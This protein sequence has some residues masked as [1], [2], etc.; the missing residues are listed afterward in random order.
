[1]PDTI[2]LGLVQFAMTPDTDANMAKAI[3]GIRDAARQGATVVCLPEL[4]RSPYFCQTEDADHFA[5]AEAIPGPSTD[6][7]AEVTRE[8][9]VVVVGSLFERR[10]KGLYHNTAAILDG[11]AGYVGK[12]RKM[13]IPDDPLFYEKY[14]FAPGDLGFKTWETSRGDLG[15]LI[16]W[17]QWY[18][19]AARLTAL[20]GADVLFYPTAIGWHPS[21]KAEYG[22]AQR[23]AWITAQRAHAISNGVYVAAVNR[24]GFEPTDWNDEEAEASRARYSVLGRVVRRRTGRTDRRAD[25]RA[26]GRR[27]R[28]PRHA[29]PDRRTASRLALPPRPPHRRLLGPDATVFARVAI[30]TSS[31]YGGEVPAGRRGLAV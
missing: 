5:L 13:H 7:L 11:D 30:H 17:D 10:A 22:H 18:P 14:Y 12:Y 8:L 23:D 2:P 27:P 6:A 9:N 29:R 28:R 31:P 20:Q 26:R 21:E 16:C 1:M 4:F 19:E 3:D 25:G 24:T 15:V